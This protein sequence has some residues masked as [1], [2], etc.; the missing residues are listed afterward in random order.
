MIIEYILIAIITCMSTF[1][2]FTNQGD[3]VPHRFYLPVAIASSIWPAFLFFMIING[4][5]DLRDSLE[6][7]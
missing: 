1:V 3:V 5:I 2:I 6:G 7:T 4:I